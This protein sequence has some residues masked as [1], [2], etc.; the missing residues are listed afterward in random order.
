[1]TQTNKDGE[2]VPI[3]Y[4]HDYILG[5]SATGTTKEFP[6][7]DEKTHVNKLNANDKCYCTKL[8][9]ERIDEIIWKKLDE[10]LNYRDDLS[11]RFSDTSFLSNTPTY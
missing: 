7:L 8:S 10:L 6:T 2:E 4:T 1:M 9:W 5:T 11:D 3:L